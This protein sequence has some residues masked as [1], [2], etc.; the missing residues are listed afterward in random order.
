VSEAT[1]TS[2]IVRDP[3]LAALQLAAGQFRLAFSPTAVIAGLPLKDGRLTPRAL[4]RAGERAG[5]ELQ[6]IKR[7]KRT[8]EAVTLPALFILQDGEAIVFTSRDGDRLVG[9]DAVSSELRSL[10]PAELKK[11][12]TL[13]YG[14]RPKL[15]YDS[16]V[17]H[18]LS[19]KKS[20]WFWST[21]LMQFRDYGYVL[22]AALLVNL[23]ALASPFFVM[24]VYDRVVPTK[25]NETLATL[26]AGMLLIIFFDFAVRQ[27]RSKLVD[28]ASHHADQRLSQRLMQKMLALRMD[29]KPASAGSF[30][31][32]LGDFDHLREFFTSAVVIALVD[33]PFVFLFLAMIYLLDGNL[34]LVPV[35][36]IIVS[37]VA[38]VM[39]HLKL[40]A[41]SQELQAVSAQKQAL[42]VEAVGALETVKGLTAQSAIQYRWERLS[43]QASLLGQQQRETSN[44]AMY[45]NSTLQQITTVG[46]VFVGV[47][48][49]F[50]GDMTTGGLI[51][52][53]MLSARALAPLAQVTGL[54]T[55]LSRM[56]SALQGLQQLMAKP[57]EGEQD[58]QRVH[59]PQISGVIECR[60]VSFNYPGQINPA[61]GK[62]SFTVNEGERVGVIG[63]SGSGKSTLVKLLLGLHEPASGSLLIDGLDAGQINLYDRRRAMAYVGQD[64]VLMFGS[65]RHNITLGEPLSSDEEILEAVRLAGLQDLVRQL[66]LGLASVIGERGDGLSGG[67]KQAL[68]MA[69][70]LIR[71]A[72]VLLLD[73]PTSSMDA[74]TE[75]QLIANMKTH[76][77][78]RTL[79][80][81]T[82]K[83]AMLELVDR[84]IVIEA[85]R[86]V[87]DGP[88]AKV[89][90]QLNEGMRLRKVG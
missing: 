57:E 64:A 27:L 45:V 24:N 59:M 34:V 70:A 63:R 84:L 3:I 43:E 32:Q 76:I 85:G 28:E 49:I 4:I 60:D 35:A 52:A 19:R 10:G 21:I 83:P 75:R 81:S 86:V 51:A 5:L 33:L 17:W 48:S 41:N 53:T 87:A 29:A 62:V 8:A 7:G 22:I 58:S 90:E 12:S 23:F 65:L 67:Q 71:N 55:R 44:N 37:I 11:K 9:V 54:L 80:V 74:T 47:H 39:A 89:L 68:L 25:A 40:A 61:L 72:P 15:Q 50:N 30:A 6:S 78:G 46:I 69:R 31:S 66:P 18:L 73:E 56:L 88:K 77:A 14:I 2:K 26:A 42:A 36:C 20:A 79:I 13:L 38:A 82:H 16:R 1:T